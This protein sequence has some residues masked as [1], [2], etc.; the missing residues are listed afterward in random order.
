MA[1]S[2]R[3]TVER[4]EGEGILA[5]PLGAALEAAGSGS[6]S[7]ASGWELRAT[8]PARKRRAEKDTGVT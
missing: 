6:C 4:A 7:A 2:A 1:N 3:L 5:S 8:L